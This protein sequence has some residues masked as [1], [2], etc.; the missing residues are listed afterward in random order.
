MQT[1]KRWSHLK[2][3]QVEWIS[4]VTKEEYDRYIEKYKKQPHK[5]GKNEIVDKVYDRINEREIWIPYYE[6][7][8]HI[9]KYIDRHNRKPHDVIDENG[10]KIM[11][12]PVTVKPK[13]PA[14]AFND[15]PDDIKAEFADKIKCGII[16]YINQTSKVPPDKVRD[17]YLKNI[18][19]GF[20]TKQ[21]KRTGAK[22]LIDE[23]LLSLYDDMK[24]DLYDDFR[25]NG[26]KNN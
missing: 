11:I 9:G 18:V 25:A 10:E 20:N 16:Y 3:K 14:S 24:K 21:Y 5:S 15:L 26:K 2:Q 17:N 1:N 7:K 8:A 19:R 6:A 13:L 23:P 12:N 22:V 4:Q